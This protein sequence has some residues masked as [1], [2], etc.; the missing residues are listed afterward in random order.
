MEGLQ[1]R[2]AKHLALAGPFGRQVGETGNSHAVW[3]PSIDRCLDEIWCEEGEREIRLTVPACLARPC[4][5]AE[6]M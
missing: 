3:E 1:H 4:S 2:E 5:R 6:E